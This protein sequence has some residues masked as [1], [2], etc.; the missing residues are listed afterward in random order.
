MHTVLTYKATHSPKIVQ[1][2]LPLQTAIASANALYD[3]GQTFA[4]HGL[5]VS[6][7]C[8]VVMT[9][10]DAARAVE[11]GCLPPARPSNK[12][13]LIHQCGGY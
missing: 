6:G 1:A 4:N 12:S 11:A 7:V 2:G 5:L 13:L 3:A 8:V 10:E 9:D